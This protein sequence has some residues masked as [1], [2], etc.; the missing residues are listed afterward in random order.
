M[1]DKYLARTNSWSWRLSRG[2]NTV[3]VCYCRKDISNKAQGQQ[4]SDPQ[5]LPGAVCF[6]G[7]LG[8]TVL[9]SQVWIWDYLEGQK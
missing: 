3:L 1:L 9:L 5:E 4:D 8:N 6:K 7:G 2:E